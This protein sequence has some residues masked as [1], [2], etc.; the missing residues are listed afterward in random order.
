VLRLIEVNRYADARAAMQH[1]LERFP[2][3]SFMRQM[4]ARADQITRAGPLR[5]PIGTPPQH[6]S[7][8]LF[9]ALLSPRVPCTEP[10]RKA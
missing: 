8:V 2:E 1:Y 6:E 3:D 7:P 9:F 4:L 5:A 10:W